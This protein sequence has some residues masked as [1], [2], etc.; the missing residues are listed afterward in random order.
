MQS[1]SAA[2][3]S[4][5]DEVYESKEAD[6]ISEDSNLYGR[7]SDREKSSSFK[8]K[9]SKEQ[10][11]IQR[12]RENI[13]D[14]YEN[15]GYGSHA[16]GLKAQKGRREQEIV[17][18]QRQH[19]YR[20]SGQIIQDFEEQKQPSSLEHQRVMKD[21]GEELKRYEAAVSG[22]VFF[23]KF[24]NTV[25]KSLAQKDVLMLGQRLSQLESENKHKQE[26][27]DIRGEQVRMLSQMMLLT[28]GKGTGGKQSDEKIRRQQE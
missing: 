17:D 13:E 24:Q 2:S 21:L 6:V 15:D 19:D 27:A 4:I 26:I 7:P 3:A 1:Q 8:N 10:E 12:I 25:S 20:M 5:A 23:E 16:Q 28:A 14:D 22:S 18:K 9:K 11:K